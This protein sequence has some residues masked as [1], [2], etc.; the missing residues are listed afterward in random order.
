MSLEQ[1]RK[2]LD[3]NFPTSDVQTRKEVAAEIHALYASERGGDTQVLKVA[4]AVALHEW[5][6]A[7]APALDVSDTILRA[8]DARVGAKASGFCDPYFESTVKQALNK[9]SPTWDDSGR[10]S[11]PDAAARAIRAL[12]EAK[13]T[14]EQR[15]KELDAALSKSSER[16]LECAEKLRVAELKLH[17]ELKRN[18]ENIEQRAIA[19][20]EACG[21]TKRTERE[22]RIN[23][24]EWTT[25][26]S[27]G[28]KVAP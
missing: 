2:V 5:R 12:A 21:W 9:T 3:Y 28:R 13:A 26:R 1:V 6:D 17:A 4:I 19:A 15:V 23:V 10:E 22:T 20:L 14:A 24:V 18:E 27:L 11:I 16:G 8:I 7:G 25:L